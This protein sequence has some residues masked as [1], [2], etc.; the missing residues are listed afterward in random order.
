MLFRS[1]T[2]GVTLV[3][4]MDCVMTFFGSSANDASFNAWMTDWGNETNRG[5]IEGINSMMPLLSILI[6]FGGFM[7]FD[8]EQSKSWSIIYIVIGGFVFAL[9]LLGFW[10]IEEPNIRRKKE[11]Y[12]K[13]VLY[14]FRWKVIKENTLLYLILT[15]FSIFGISIQ[16]FVTMISSLSSPGQY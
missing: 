11:G 5:K 14:S 9:G 6:V 16:M 2:L 10:L 1:G 8:L 15:A 4:I 3:V 13:T 12:W 7:A